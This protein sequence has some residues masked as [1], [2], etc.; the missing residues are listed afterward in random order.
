V[1]TQAEFL[2][3]LFDEKSFS[4]TAAM[5]DMERVLPAGVQVTALE[6]AR[7]KDGRLTLRLRI[8]GQR[9]RSVELVRNMEH[10]RRFIDPRVAGENSEAGSNAQGNLQPVS[11]VAAK[12]SFD[13]L[14]EYSPATLEERKAMIAA[15]KQKHP[16]STGS[17]QSK[18]QS[19][20][21]GR[22]RYM[23]PNP[24]AVPRQTPLPGQP[25]FQRPL[26]GPIRGPNRNRIPIP[27]APQPNATPGDPQ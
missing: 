23:P 2:N 22:A 3:H 21:S 14:A 1:L 19:A 20:P 8:S 17:P 27:G 24:Q 6:P 5:E 10:S 25:P 12:V 26:P 18:L 13:I 9:E 7:G 15:Q 16:A 4:W 11:T